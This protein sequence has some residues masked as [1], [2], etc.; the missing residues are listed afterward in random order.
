MGL[1]SGLNLAFAEGPLSVQLRIGDDSGSATV[2][3]RGT[4]VYP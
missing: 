1:A 3:M 4:L 2:P